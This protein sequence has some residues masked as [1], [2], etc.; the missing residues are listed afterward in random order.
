MY[1]LTREKSS[2]HSSSPQTFFTHLLNLCFGDFLPDDLASASEDRAIINTEDSNMLI[3]IN[4]SILPAMD[5]MF[6]SCLIN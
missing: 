4:P 2:E 5:Q 3:T 6:N 1:C